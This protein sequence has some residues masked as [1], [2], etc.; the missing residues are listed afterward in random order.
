MA[1]PMQVNELRD[2]GSLMLTWV[3]FSDYTASAAELQSAARELF[4]AI[5]S[6]ALQPPAAQCLP[7][8]QAVEAHRLLEGGRT[9]GPLLLLP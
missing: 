5:A 6:G 3:R 1:P 9:T 2:R 7:L 8:E 4:E